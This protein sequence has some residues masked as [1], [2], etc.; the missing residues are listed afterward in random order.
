NAC[1]ANPRDPL[2]TDTQVRLESY[3]AGVYSNVPAFEYWVNGG[4]LLS[5]RAIGIWDLSDVRL[6]PGEYTVVAK[7]NDGCDCTNIQT[8]TVTVTN[9]CTPC[10]TMEQVCWT[11][12]DGLKQQKFRAKVGEFA[13]TK[14]S[15]F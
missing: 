2:N 10:L 13:T 8:K 15:K 6:K 7:A 4:K 14:R 11:P 3:A 9:F 1:P 12:P 5:N